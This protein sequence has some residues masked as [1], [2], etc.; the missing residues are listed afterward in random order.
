MGVLRIATQGIEFVYLGAKGFALGIAQGA[1][2]QGTAYIQ[3]QDL[4]LIEPL[5]V[6]M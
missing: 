4:A 6:T 3:S 2:G 5:I 1:K